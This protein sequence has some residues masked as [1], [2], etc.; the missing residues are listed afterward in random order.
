VVE[1]LKLID[2]LSR[3][4][5]QFDIQELNQL[6]DVVCSTRGIHVA[7]EAKLLKGWDFVAEVF[8]VRLKSGTGLPGQ[9]AVARSV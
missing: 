7:K 1:G 5:V 2:G 8:E 6:L 4:V 9:T 3:N